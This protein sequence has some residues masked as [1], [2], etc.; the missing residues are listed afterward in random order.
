MTTLFFLD[1]NILIY[2]RDY[3]DPQKQKIAARWLR[4]LAASEQAVVNLQAINEVR[5]VALHKLTR[6]GAD[7]I[8]DWT[9]DLKALGDTTVDEDTAAGAWAI[10]LKYRLSWFDCMVLSAA[11][12][13]G[14]S[15]VVTEDMGAD[16]QIGPLNLINPFLHDVDDVLTETN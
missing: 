13:L 8:R 3:R 9:D 6:L 11:E 15:H 5:H 10:H 1:A 2:T 7:A 12:R 16:R 4:R 14:C